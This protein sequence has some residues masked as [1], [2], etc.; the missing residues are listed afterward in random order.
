M[1][2]VISILVSAAKRMAIELLYKVIG[3]SLIEIRKSKGLR[4]DP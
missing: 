4:M 3:M 2:V 1:E